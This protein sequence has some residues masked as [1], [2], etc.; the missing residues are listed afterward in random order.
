MR[1]RLY[2]WDV[3]EEREM[4]D[5]PCGMFDE[6]VIYSCSADLMFLSSVCALF[7]TK[8]NGCDNEDL[9][10]RSRPQNKFA[11]N[12]PPSRVLTISPTH[13][14]PSKHLPHPPRLG[15]VVVS[16]PPTAVLA[17]KTKAE[18]QRTDSWSA[19]SVRRI[20]SQSQSLER[21]PVQ[22]RRRGMK[23]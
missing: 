23:R 15:T 6:E 5:T 12:T 20:R 13:E 21:F 14:T 2:R 18:I 4:N 19:A 3:L 9:H 17:P 1:I 7:P 16:L 11:R 8:S 10:I 22:G